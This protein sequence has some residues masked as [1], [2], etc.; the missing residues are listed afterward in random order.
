[1]TVKYITLALRFHRSVVV[2]AGGGVARFK[3]MARAILLTLF[4][5]EFCSELLHPLPHQPLFKN[6]TEKKTTTQKSNKTPAFINTRFIKM[7]VERNP[8]PTTKK[9]KLLD[10]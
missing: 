8:P 1:M 5:R 4:V 2:F 3:T 9:V 7:G 10:L 6:V